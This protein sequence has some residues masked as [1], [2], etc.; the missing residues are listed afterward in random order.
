MV[1]NL[2]F[3]ALI[4]LVLS[5]FIGVFF[6]W[7]TY[8]VFLNRF[9]RKYDLT[10]I[11]L[12]FAILLSAVLF[13]TG[14]ILSGT[15]SPLLNTL[16]ILSRNNPGG[17]ILIIDSLRYV[18]EFLLIGF[19]VALLVNYISINLFN[20]FTPEKDELKEIRENKFQYSLIFAAILIVISLFAKEAYT[21]LLDSLIPLPPLPKIF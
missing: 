2:T 21:A 17:A 14:Y 11:N 1:Q 16:R 5:I 3:L 4:Q 20:A 8:K 10:E 18:G 9:K 7:V 19:V 15:L 6:M 12:G 13:S